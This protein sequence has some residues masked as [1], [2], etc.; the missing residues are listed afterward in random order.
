MIS[1]LSSQNT[2]LLYSSQREPRETGHF[3]NDFH[4][5]NF[6]AVIHSNLNHNGARRHTVDRIFGVAN[7]NDSRR[8]V[9][10]C[11]SE[12]HTSELQSRSDLVCRL[13]LAKKKVPS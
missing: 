1:R 5:F 10:V 13:L 3:A 12:E 11:R 9:C 2:P 6:P 4:A 8:D 7:G